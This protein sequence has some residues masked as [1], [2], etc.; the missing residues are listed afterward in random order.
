MLRTAGSKRFEKARDW[1]LEQ[2]R[3]AVV[4]DPTSE[5]VAD[6]VAAYDA[7][8][9]HYRRNAEAA[10][11]L[12]RPAEARRWYA[13]LIDGPDLLFWSGAQRGQDALSR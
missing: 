4:R 13:S 7:E 1:W 10:A 8:L 3:A 5:E 11:A 2:S 12:N 6:L 9:A